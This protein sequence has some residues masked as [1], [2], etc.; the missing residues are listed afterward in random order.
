MPLLMGMLAACVGVL[1]AAL[2]SP[3]LH[4][5]PRLQRF[6]IALLSVTAAAVAVGAAVAVQ[7]WITA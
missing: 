2:D 6:G 3:S 4:D 1:L 5:Q 7:R